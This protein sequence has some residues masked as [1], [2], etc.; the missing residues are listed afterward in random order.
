MD[1]VRFCPGTRHTMW[2]ALWVYLLCK[3]PHALE[4]ARTRRRRRRRRKE[5]T[6]DSVLRSSVCIW[7]L[8]L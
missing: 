1:F 5:R 4:E 6:V 2:D 7:V 8:Q 3:S